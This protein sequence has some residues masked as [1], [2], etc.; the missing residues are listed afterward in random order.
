MYSVYYF[1][2]LMKGVSKLDES[3]Q[4]KKRRAWLWLLI[5]PFI[6]TLFPEFYAYNQ[7]TVWGFPVFYW[8][9][10]L[11]VIISA[12]ITGIVYAVTK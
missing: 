3:S 12:I 11:W 10:L 5:I 9:Q 2:I 8:Y 1:L 4:Y 6:A 7:P